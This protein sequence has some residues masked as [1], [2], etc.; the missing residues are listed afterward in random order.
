MTLRPTPFLAALGLAALLASACGSDDS[1][2][3]AAGEAPTTTA[4]GEGTTDTTAAG[5]TTETTVEE[6]VP[7][8]PTATEAAELRA[9]LTAA[10]QEHVY[11]AGQAIGAA[12]ETGPQSPA[13]AAASAT[14]DDNSVAI[15]DA[16]STGFDPEVGEEFLALWRDHIGYFVDYAAATAGGDG[17]G[18][19]TA[20]EELD[21][22]RQDTGDLLES[23]SDD[24]LSASAVASDLETHVD[25]ILVTIDAIVAGSPEVYPLLQE[26]ATHMS[27]TA[28]VLAAA[29]V[30]VGE[31]EGA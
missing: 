3:A 27:G 14:L 18:A 21:Q 19:E 22:Y 1:F 4:E 11:L 12:L 15:G 20:Q 8:G 9:G 17:A 26:A 2:P 16:V 7:G 29:V 28:A 31:A 10:L 6:D 5:E 23:A 13:T 30:E 24:V 25:G